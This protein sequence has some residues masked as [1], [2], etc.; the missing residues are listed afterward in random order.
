MKTDQAGGNSGGTRRRSWGRRIVGFVW[1]TVCFVKELV[2]ANIS[3]ARTVLFQHRENFAPDFLNYELRGLTPFEIVVLTHCIT[4]TP[5]TTSVEVS[6][7][8]TTLLVHALDARDPEAV[9]DSIKKGLE[10]PLLAW[11][12]GNES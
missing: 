9:R 3:V 2:S 12:R 7:D 10:M 11:T 1:F 5:G 4:L 6:E 8:Q